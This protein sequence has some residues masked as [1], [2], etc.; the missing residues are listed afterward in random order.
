MLKKLL[1]LLLHKNMHKHRYSSSDRYTYRPHRHPSQYGYKH[2]K[3]KHRSHSIFSSFF[4]S[5]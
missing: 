3:K 2:Y 5:S 1:E 4:G